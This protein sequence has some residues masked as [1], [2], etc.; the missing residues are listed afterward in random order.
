MILQALRQMRADKA[1]IQGPYESL[2]GVLH[3]MRAGKN[4]CRPFDQC[5]G[6]LTKSS[7]VNTLLQKYWRHLWKSEHQ[8]KGSRRKW[9]SSATVIGPARLPKWPLG[10][11]ICSAQEYHKYRPVSLPKQ[12]DRLMLFVSDSVQSSWSLGWSV[13]LS[14]VS[15]LHLPPPQPAPFIAIVDP[16]FLCPPLHFPTSLIL[17]LRP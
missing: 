17:C 6:A 14:P 3:S 1:K 2:L 12:S 8:T 4:Y 15:L 10:Q 16:P 7:T 13:V 5:D 9:L 11:Y